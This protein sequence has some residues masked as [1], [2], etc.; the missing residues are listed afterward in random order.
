MKKLAV[1]FAGLAIL[2]SALAYDDELTWVYDESKRPADVVSVKPADRSAG[3]DARAN[4]ARTLETTPAG[5]SLESRGWSSW[6]G[7]LLELTRSGL[8][9]L[10]R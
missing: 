5:A 1:A 6:L 9:I 4:V 8:S 10:I 2:G 7:G 3:V